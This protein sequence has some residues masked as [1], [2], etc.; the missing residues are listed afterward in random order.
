MEFMHTCKSALD[1]LYTSRPDPLTRIRSESREAT[2]RGRTAIGY[3]MMEFLDVA[4]TKYPGDRWP[5][6]QRDWYPVCEWIAENA[7]VH[8]ALDPLNRTPVNVTSL[9]SF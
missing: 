3:A 5:R 8:P 9:G 4:R 7:Y 2:D 6:K 1:Y